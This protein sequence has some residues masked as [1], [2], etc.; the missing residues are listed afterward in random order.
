MQVL[1][2]SAAV[3]RIT[4][5]PKAVDRTRVQGEEGDHRRNSQQQGRWRSILSDTLDVGL[6]HR[7][8][9]D[10][11]EPILAVSRSSRRRSIRTRIQAPWMRS[12]RRRAAATRS[13]PS[14]IPSGIISTAPSCLRCW[15][16]SAATITCAFTAWNP[17]TTSELAGTAGR[18]GPRA[19]CQQNKDI[20]PDDHQQ[21]IPATDGNSLVLTI[22]SD[23]QNYPGKAP[24]DRAGGQSGG[25]RRRFGHRDG[26]QDRRGASD[27]QPAGL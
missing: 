1:A 20:M 4:V 22:D 10:P 12:S 26:R 17:S 7:A 9:E 15:D 21:Y 8:G 11:E 25:A 13:T 14:R 6:R 2:E 27:G 16:M 23:I 19:E 5:D 24:G 3:A 18:H